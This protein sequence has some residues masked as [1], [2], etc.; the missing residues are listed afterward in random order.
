ML[1]LIKQHPLLSILVLAAFL[2]LFWLAKVPPA[3]NWDET[4]MGY[5]AYSLLKTGRDEWGE[6]LPLFFRSYGEWKSAVYIYLL[7]PFVKIFGLNAWAVR[8]PSA[9]AGIL[10]V[11]LTYLIGKSIYSE[12][13]GLWAAF[14]LTISP[15]HLMLSRPAFEANLS[16]TLILAGTYF[17]IRFVSNSHATSYLLL[18]T[19]SFGLAPHT[20]N[21]A[22][23][24]VPFLVLWLVYQY[25]SFFLKA[26]KQLFLFFFILAI[27]ALPI[28]EN[29]LTGK[30]QKRYGQVGVTTDTYHL[31]LFYQYRHTFPLPQ[32]IN[33]FIFNK[34]TFFVYHFTDNWLAYFS[35]NFLLTEGGDHNQHSIPYRGIIYFSTF[36]FIIFGLTQLKKQKHPLKYLPLVIIGLGFV[37]P[38]TTRETHHVLRSILTLPGWQLLAALGVTYLA[39]TKKHQKI[40]A[41]CYLLLATE[42]ISFLLMYFFWYPKAFARDWQYGYQQAIQFAEAHRQEYPQVVM[43]KWYGE[44]QIFVAFYTKW[45]PVDFQKQN[46]K[47]LRYEKEGK[48]WLDQLD[49]YKIGRYTF[50]YL[51]WPNEPKDKQTLYIGKFDDFPYGAKILKTIYFPDGSVAFHLAV[52]E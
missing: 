10:A 31:N 48:I 45:D 8:L 1:K 15:F 26:K 13:V 5:T 40:L 43:T 46:L 6:K 20:Y 4:S 18:A 30:A 9:L 38:A 22:K 42:V 33:K 36:I 27:F 28:A 37:P 17:F 11:Y 51:D 12:K 7:V 35:P 47:L 16:L 44:P 23:V 19:I 24:V 25:R 34:Y 52:A 50:K 21:S 3:L 29:I 39:S 49:E 2:R 14:F 32:K 41:T